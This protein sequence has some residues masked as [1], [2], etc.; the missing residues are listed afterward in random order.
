MKVYKEKSVQDFPPSAANTTQW[1]FSGAFNR[2]TWSSSVEFAHLSSF[3]VRVILK[4]RLDSWKT[5]SRKLFIGQ[6]LWTL[7]WVCF[8]K[9]LVCLAE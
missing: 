3:L 7:S 2:I 5:R 8:L 1:L 9:S 4:I 6:N